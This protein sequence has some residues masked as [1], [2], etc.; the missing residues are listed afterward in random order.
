MGGWPALVCLF[1][2]VWF[3]W[4]GLFFCLLAGWL[5]GRLVVF[6]RFVWRIDV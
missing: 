5:V 6:W 3:C 4:V 1:G 2:F